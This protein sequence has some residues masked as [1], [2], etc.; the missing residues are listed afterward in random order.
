MGSSIA[1]FSTELRR[2]AGSARVSRLSVSY[3]YDVT[4]FSL[5]TF[6]LCREN[7]NKLSHL[8]F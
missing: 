6:G 8:Y 3:D 2:T 5:F 7:E 1:W 4:I